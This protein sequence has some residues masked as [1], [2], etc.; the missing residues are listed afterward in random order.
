[1]HGTLAP[2]GLGVA[3]VLSSAGWSAACAQAT[4][5][6]KT[7]SLGKL[8]ENPV[9]LAEDG[10]GL[11][12]ETDSIGL[13]GPNWA[14]GFDPSAAG[15]IRVSGLYADLLEPLTARVS[16]RSVVQVGSTTLGALLPAPSGLVDYHIR[17]TGTD[18]A[19]FSL[20]TGLRA[21]NV[22]GLQWSQVDE[23]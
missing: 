16:D 12:T 13:Y 21:A 4:D 14:R 17:Q 22:T 15:N 6:A 10:F 19:T 2:A 9:A 18:M 8:N 11:V 1:V 3:F 23:E 5:T 7:G 20:S